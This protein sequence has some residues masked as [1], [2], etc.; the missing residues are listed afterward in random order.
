MIEMHI[1][2]EGEREREGGG[3]G[4]GGN[5]IRMTMIVVAF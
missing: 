1:W 5:Y 3:R 4:G 2:G